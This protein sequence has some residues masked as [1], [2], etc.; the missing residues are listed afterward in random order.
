MRVV[1][2]VDKARKHKKKNEWYESKTQ[3]KSGHK[4]GRQQKLGHRSRKALMFLMLSIL[5]NIWST[6]EIKL[7]IYVERWEFTIK[8][9]KETDQRITAK[10]RIK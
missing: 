8:E 6:L 9:R 4:K 3:D 7:V 1:G 10:E 2:C 5:L